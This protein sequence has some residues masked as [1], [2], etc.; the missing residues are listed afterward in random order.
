MFKKKLHEVSDKWYE[1]FDVKIEL[2]HPNRMPITY[3]VNRPQK[4]DRDAGGRGPIELTLFTDQYRFGKRTYES[5]VSVPNEN[6]MRAKFDGDP[7]TV[8]D[9][10][11][12]YSKKYTRGELFG[13][14][15]FLYAWGLAELFNDDEFNKLLPQYGIKTMDPVNILPEVSEIQEEIIEIPYV[16]AVS[17]NFTVY[18][19]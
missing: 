3:R 19:N 10:Y 11:E 17:L 16:D 9:I 6:H 14:A 5:R 2:T 15:L 18:T 12:V 7:H 13:T 1:M 4:T 8:E